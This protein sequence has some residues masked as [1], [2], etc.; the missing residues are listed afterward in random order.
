MIVFES[1]RYDPV[2]HRREPQRVAI[3]TSSKLGRPT[4]GDDDVL[5]ALIYVPKEQT[6]FEDA[7]VSFSSR[8]VYSIVGWDRNSRSYGQLKLVLRRLKAVTVTC[9]NA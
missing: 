2:S 3:T 8:D 9:E 5:L 6:D 7:R 1:S 4:P